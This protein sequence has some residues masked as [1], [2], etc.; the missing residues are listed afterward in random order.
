MG[1]PTLCRASGEHARPDLMVNRLFLI[2]PSFSFL[3]DRLNKYI[4]HR[5]CESRQRW[6]GTP[7][8]EHQVKLLKRLLD[9]FEGKLTSSK[10]SAIATCRA[11]T[12]LRNII[13]R[14]GLGVL[15]K[16]PGGGRSTAYELRNFFAS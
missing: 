14:M 3:S 15:R 2:T 13:E 6:A 8:N 1:K 9:G 4:S 16:A 10:W 12:A 7:M 5:L 11:D